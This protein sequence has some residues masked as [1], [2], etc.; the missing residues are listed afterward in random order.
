[1]ISCD[2]RV[3]QDQ[4]SRSNQVKLGLD[5]S[6]LVVVAQLRGLSVN[7]KEQISLA[8]ALWDVS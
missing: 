6:E 7:T 2:Y 1:M 5:L 3:S 8:V 4:R